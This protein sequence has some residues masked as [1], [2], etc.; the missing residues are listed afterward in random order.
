ME[1]KLCAICKRVT[2]YN[3]AQHSDQWSAPAGAAALYTCVCNP[4]SRAGV[5]AHCVLILYSSVHTEASWSIEVLQPVAVHAQSGIQ[6]QLG[7]RVDV[8]E[9]IGAKGKEKRRN[10]ESAS[11]TLAKCSDKAQRTTFKDTLE[12]NLKF[13]DH[14]RMRRT[15]C[16][17]KA[18]QAILYHHAAR[19]N[20]NLALKYK[21]PSRKK[22]WNRFETKIPLS[23][24]N[25]TLGCDAPLLLDW[26]L[27]LEANLNSKTT[28]W[29][30]WSRKTIRSGI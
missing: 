24:P 13:R 21:Y 7:D 25:D 6:L 2:G 16:S 22:V 11:C 14:L 9:R 8:V 28:F 19:D 12:R 10:L 4:T 1:R 26:D 15:S 30:K 18:R 20:F 23:W 17:I 27:I 5:P 29:T 3:L